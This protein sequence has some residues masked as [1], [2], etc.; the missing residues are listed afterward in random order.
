MCIYIPA[1][2]LVVLSMFENYNLD[3]IINEQM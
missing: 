1:N 3:L 2:F